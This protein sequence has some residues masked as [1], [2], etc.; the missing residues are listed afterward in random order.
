MLV[1]PHEVFKI[2]ISRIV[3]KELKLTHGMPVNLS[4]DEGFIHL[5]PC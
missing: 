4:I 3:A 2:R 1:T 5:I